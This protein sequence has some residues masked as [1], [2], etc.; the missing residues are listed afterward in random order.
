MTTKVLGIS[1]PRPL[2]ERGEYPRAGFAFSVS[3]LPQGDGQPAQD[4]PW[5]ARDEPWPAQALL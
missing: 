1:E 5:P 2:Q 3:P 4:E